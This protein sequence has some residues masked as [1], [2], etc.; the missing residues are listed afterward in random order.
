MASAVCLLLSLMLGGAWTSGHHQFE[1]DV[2]ASN[3]SA[4]NDTIIVTINPGQQ[5]RGFYRAL[6]TGTVIYK[7]WGIRFGQSTTG[8]C[9]FSMD[10]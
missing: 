5:L 7:F 9:S 8:M 2:D 1:R 4:R 3:S 10:G 6:A